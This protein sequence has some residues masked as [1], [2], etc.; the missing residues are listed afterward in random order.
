MPRYP[1]SRP[2]QPTPRIPDAAIAVLAAAA[3]RLV[4]ARDGSLQHAGCSPLGGEESVRAG[5]SVSI[6]REG[7]VEG[8]SITTRAT[9]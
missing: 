7:Y 2:T 3:F 1:V 9:G 8:S 6:E 4:H 5:I